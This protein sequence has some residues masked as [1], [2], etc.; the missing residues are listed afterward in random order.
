MGDL[1]SL[2][3]P[4]MPL[5]PR[6]FPLGKANV[7][8][9]DEL[10]A[11]S[12]SLPTWASVIGLSR[13]EEWVLEN[14]EWSYPRFYLNKPVRDLA[15]AVLH[16][17][18]ITDKSISC[19]VFRSANAARLCAADLQAVASDSQFR[20]LQTVQF[21]M[22]L[23][24][25]WGSS[26]T[27]WANF[28][29]VLFP[30]DLKKQAMA[31]WRDTGAG[32]ST[33]HA[34][35]CLEEL[36]YLDSDSSEPTFRTPALQKRSCRQSQQSV[37]LTQSADSSMGEIKTFLAQLATSEQPGQPAVDPD[38]VFL[39]PN[40]MNA[41]Y[42]LSE[43]VASFAADSTVAAYGWLYPE[44]VDVLK[45]GPWGKLLSFK[46]GSEE[47]LDQLESMLE[48]GQQIRALFCELPSN[49]KLS[50]PNLHRIRAL[51]DK[52]DFLVAC[53][54]TVAGYVNVDALPYV[55]VM[56][57]S[58]TKTFSGF[59][60]VTGGSL[61]INPSSRH[62]QTLHNIISAQYE[63]I[64][65]PLDVEVIAKN[66]K[67]MSWRVR[68]CSQNT[69]PLVKLLQSHPSVAQVNHPSIAPT[70]PVYRS[71]MRKDGGYGN[72]LSIIFHHPRSA[73]HFYNVLDICK[74][75]SFGTNFTL[76]IPYVQLANYWNR[77]KVPKYGVPQ[78]IIRISV[79]LEDS[80]SIVNAVAAALREVE[81]F[82]SGDV[83]IGDA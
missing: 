57:S 40:G 70:E 66:S 45:R 47:E 49:I 11:V 7:Y 60:N 41:I 14:L 83:L 21:V 51:A 80:E 75:S 58:L 82:E 23:E 38:D 34:T 15:D 81:I 8:P 24:S 68:Q 77:E 13:K 69:L 6:A 4:W 78:H 74:G 36:D 22:P 18:Q 27:H 52:H 65:F 31:F 29:A 32:L 43:G 37:M 50:S 42:A 59:S 61:V 76:A 2:S 3:E 72:V 26:A 71:L 35:Y 17:L 19:M 25:N 46:D 73:E 63:N 9:L 56:M 5:A 20:V 28:T 33:R 30:G 16:R 1:G 55:D 64:Y 48:S 67:N 12:V 44:T 10:H 54:D 53:D 39:Y 62:R 79:G